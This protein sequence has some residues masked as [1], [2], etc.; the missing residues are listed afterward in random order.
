MVVFVSVVVFDVEE[1]AVEVVGV[2]DVVVDTN[3]YHDSVCWPC[4]SMA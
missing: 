2:P 1:D 3:R 4:H